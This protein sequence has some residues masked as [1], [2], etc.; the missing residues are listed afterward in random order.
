MSLDFNTEPYYD[1]FDED[2][3]FHRILFKPGVAVQARELTQLQTILQNQV[4]RFGRHVFKEGA[5][6]IPG[7]ASVDTKANYV[8]VGTITNTT[9]DDLVETLIYST[10]GVIAKVIAVSTASGSDPNTLIIKYINSDTAGTTKE[11][12]AG[13]TLYLESTLTTSFAT[14]GAAPSTPTGLAS[15][16]QINEGVYFINGNFVRID[17]QTIILEKYNNTPTYRI[18]LLIDEQLISS[19]EDASL[20]D[21][22][23]G[24][25]N[26]A[27]PGADRYKIIGTLAK[28]EVD[29]VLDQDFIELI[30][31]KNGQVL[32]Q[33]SVTD[34]SILEKTLARRTYDE[35]G[36]YT[37]R[38][39]QIQ[40]RE[41]R[42]NNRGAFASSTYYA[43]NDVVSYLGNAYVCISAYTS[44]ASPVPTTNW[45]M[46]NSVKYNRGVYDVTD[47]VTGNTEWAANLAIG[48][49]AGKAYVRGY[50][51]EKISSEFITI[52]KARSNASVNNDVVSAQ[53]GNYV[54]VT[55]ICNAFDTENFALVYLFDQITATRGAPAGSLVGTA[56][57][58]YIEY[59]SGTIGQTSAVYKLSLFDIQMNAD[60]TF[61]RNVKQISSVSTGTGA[62]ADIQPVLTVQNGSITIT[63][64]ALN[65]VGT[66]F[67]QKLVVGDY[68]SAN[69]NLIRVTAINSDI[70]AVISVSTVSNVTN[71][72]YS[73]VQ[74]Q[75]NE[76]DGS[77][78]LISL[79]Q[80][81]IKTVSDLS[82]QVMHKYSVTPAALAATID[83]TSLATDSGNLTYGT[84]FTSTNTSD[85]IA[86]DTTTGNIAPLSCVTLGGGDT[87]VTLSGFVTNNPHKVYAKV[88][89]TASAAPK[90]KVATSNTLVFTATE[91]S[92]STLSLNK[93]DVFKIDSILYN[94]SDI[95]DQYVLDNGQRPTH[96]AIATITRKSGYPAPTSNITVNFRY[97]NHNNNGDFF[98]VGSYGVPYEDIPSFTYQGKTIKLTDALDFR[99]CMAYT[100]NT[101]VGGGAR[102]SGMPVRDRGVTLDYEYYL[103]RKDKICLDPEGRFFSIQGV[104]SLNPIEP[105]D[106][107]GAMVLYKLDLQPYTL[108]END[109]IVNYVDNKR[110][111]MRDIGRL[112]QRIE[113]IEYYTALSLLEQETKQFQIYDANGL[114]RYK[115]GFLVDNFE[116]HGVGDVTQPDYLCSID[117]ENNQLRPFFRMDNFNLI[118]TSTTNIQITGD[119]ATLPYTH[120][121]L[122]DQ[123]YASRT[124][125]VN[126]YNVFTFIGDLRLHPENDEWFEVDRR[127]DL[128]VNEEG[129]FDSIVRML[130]TQGVLGTVWNSWQTQ[131]TGVPVSRG[132][133]TQ[134]LVQG[135]QGWPIRDVTT[136]ILATTSGQARTGVRTSVVAKIDT[137]VVG[138]R[139]LST[140]AI[141]FIRARAVAFVAR[142]LKPNTK[143]YPFFEGIDVSQYVMPATKLVIG[144]PTGSF[145]SATNAGINAD[146]SARRIS[147]KVEIALNRGDKIV[148]GSNT[149]IVV[150]VDTSTVTPALYVVNIV[151]TIQAGQT[152]TGS[153]SGASATISSVTSA[154]LGGA[155]TSSL[156][157]DVA[158]LFFLPNTSATRFRTGVREF[159]LSSSST[160]VDLYNSWA[161][162]QYTAIGTL[163]TKQTTMASVRNAQVVQ[164]SLSENR[165]VTT[166]SSRVIS[167]TG[168]YDP[169][170]ETF[171]VQQDGGA[172]LTKVDL[173]FH[174][175]DTVTNLPVR[176][177]IR[178]VI[179]GYPGKR[180]LPFS[181]VVMAASDVNVSDD[182]TTATTFTFPSPVYVEN[183]GEYALVVLSDSNE[184]YIWIAQMGQLTVGGD[185][186]ISEQPYAGSLFKSQNASTWTAEQTQDLKFKIY[187]AS[188]SPLAGTITFS[189]DTLPPKLLMNN[190]LL[191]LAA[192]SIVKVY[193]PDHGIRSG[194]NVTI[195]GAADTLSANIGTA[196]VNRTHTVSNVFTDYFTINLGNVANIS[197]FIGGPNVLATRSIEFDAIQP[198]IQFQTFSNTS[199]NHYVRAT[200]Q[201]TGIIDATVGVSIVPNDTN[202]FNSAKAVLAEDNEGGSKSFVLTTYF[203]SLKE[204]LSPVIDINRASIVA[205]KNKTNNPDNVTYNID[206]ID[207]T[208]WL[209]GN[210]NIGFAA[211]STIYSN[212]A[213]AVTILKQL[214][215]G[216][217]LSIS[218]SA[219][220]TNN[221][222]VIISSIDKSTGNITVRDYTFVSMTPGNAITLITKEGFTDEIAP[223]GGSVLS[224]YITR[225]VNLKTPATMLK[226]LFDAS[227]P[228]VA[229]IDVYYKVLPTGSYKTMNETEYYR[230]NVTTSYVKTT[231]AA[232]F[233]EAMYTIDNLQP[234]SSFVI[235]LAFRSTNSSYVPVVRDLRVIACA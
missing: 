1:D 134:R 146:E 91:A 103:P 35:S 42:N 156:A 57:A 131:W 20:T 176:I 141:P 206:L 225:Q 10:S 36:D 121:S 28:L 4:A 159:K 27:A 37:V 226:I 110:Y 114:D 55:N 21:N 215:P 51:I 142:G 73:L 115:A 77:S 178:E 181:K 128:I 54:L 136:E 171:L 158:G 15:I 18:G 53:V 174:K 100:S 47:A 52:P 70:N 83:C 34:Y 224:K 32:T 19:T 147:G 74:T 154:S 227:V 187:R 87:Q 107:T 150:H 182:A 229:D 208:V 92:A 195:S 85:Y 135:N 113:N 56:R 33:V 223:Y 39:F 228:P 9:I 81:A 122:V 82:F 123:P 144:T 172:F 203:S 97:F 64:N 104:P 139:V 152:V 205:I 61:E 162:A 80:Y 59:H 105:I 163:E 69:S 230:A 106:P 41:Y 84:K 164:E 2:K 45:A 89:K 31:V 130:E 12:A 48:L 151:G 109:M 68:L 63:G 184:Y 5:M 43:Q 157:G 170:A 188:F 62:T 124:E 49:D 118:N 169:L 3:N 23:Q 153:I 143:F 66:T 204:N 67:Q 232:T 137:R 186:L 65:G 76:V 140:A 198:I 219:N 138:D 7:Q 24:S 60:K 26:Y 94:N 180:V 165:T 102:I 177:E 168:W 220:A 197:A 116:G 101:F 119:L 183:G 29:S 210:V 209:S 200:E 120:V 108:N 75:F 126:P 231:D 213:G 207:T 166:T 88:Y 44:T 71:L 211:P 78:L 40:P 111:T 149:A 125:N 167:D 212:S 90:T 221:C 196:N 86:I 190:P 117:M 160:N 145:T 58:R 38:P 217:R 22:A 193:H 199:L 16:A 98:A 161:R 8:K 50:E 191:T 132:T 155:L 127:P 214:S 6:V 112:E 185:R 173:F 233:T 218:G 235:K 202:Y 189:N 17:P 222:N 216:K 95:K 96:Y 129:N 192:N 99:P 46:D 79:P 148:S 13:E 201:S 194:T 14:V 30:R 93:A 72:S 25:Y 234:F 133:T 175:K 11:F 179:N